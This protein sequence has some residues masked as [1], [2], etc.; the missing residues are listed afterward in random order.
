MRTASFVEVKVP[1]FLYEF[2]SSRTH[3]SVGW[4]TVGSLF[5]RISTATAQ[6]FSKPTT[7]PDVDSDFGGEFDDDDPD[8][9]QPDTANNIATSAVRALRLALRR[10]AHIARYSS[11]AQVQ[12]PTQIIPRS[13]ADPAIKAS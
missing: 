3:V 5:A 1:P 11:P 12:R 2:G 10:T 7:R 9:E 6:S 13:T 4:S 8:V